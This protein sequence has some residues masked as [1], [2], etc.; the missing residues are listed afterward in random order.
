V[1]ICFS[2]FGSFA[3]LQSSIHEVWVRRY[4]SYSLSLARYTPTDCLETFPLPIKREGAALDGE[5]FF[6]YRK[7]I[8]LNSEIGLVE[9]YN[10]FHDPNEADPRIVELRGLQAAMDQ[11][12][13]S[14][15]GWSDIALNHDFFETPRDGIRYTICPDSRGELLQRLLELNHTLAAEESSNQTIGGS[16][17]GVAKRGRKPKQVLRQMP[18]DLFGGE[19]S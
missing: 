6:E 5:K 15:Y 3:V 12:T 16:T 8:C 10:K 7:N 9:I 14:T 1:V 18:G 11:S 2:D 19:S 17:K 13:L 4:T